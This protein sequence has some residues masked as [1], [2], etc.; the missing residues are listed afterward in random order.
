MELNNL[1]VLND[2]SFDIVRKN[3]SNAALDDVIR[4]ICRKI[5]SDFLHVYFN[6][7]KVSVEEF[8]SDIYNLLENSTAWDDMYVKAY[9]YFLKFG[10]IDIKRSN[11]IY[12]DL[13]EWIANQRR[14]KKSLH[15]WFNFQRRQYKKIG[16]DGNRSLSADRIEKMNLLDR[17]WWNEQY[18]TQE[19]GGGLNDRSI[20]CRR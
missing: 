5:K 18:I 3:D 13:G 8:Q 17:N 19:N 12:G 2:T 4:E 1:P 10:D 16:R 15:N 7:Q 11:K 20:L 14:N 9:Q 6:N